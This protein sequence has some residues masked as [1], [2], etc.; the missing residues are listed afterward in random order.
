MGW[1]G[2]KKPRLPLEQHQQPP[3]L[4]GCASI[5]PKIKDLTSQT[6]YDHHLSSV[7]AAVVYADATTCLNAAAVEA[8]QQTHAV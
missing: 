5:I 7:A 8:F 1:G 4:D 3:S 6:F 2:S